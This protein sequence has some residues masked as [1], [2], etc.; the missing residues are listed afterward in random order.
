MQVTQ[1]F[2]PHFY[3]YLERLGEKTCAGKFF[4]SVK[5]SCGFKTELKIG[6]VR[7]ERQTF[8]SPYAHYIEAE[9]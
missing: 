1:I 7:S 8:L 4:L 9:M 6:H 5:Q 3:F 2:A